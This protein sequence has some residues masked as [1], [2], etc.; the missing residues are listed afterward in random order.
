MLE[1][2]LGEVE[3][4]PPLAQ[5]VGGHPLLD[6]NLS[7]SWLCLAPMAHGNSQAPVA[8]EGAT[9]RNEFSLRMYPPR[10][11]LGTK[12]VSES[13][14]IATGPVLYGWTL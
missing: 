3:D 4:P 1:E 8:Q 14:S 7:R 5:H 10:T 13:G 2:P 9:A 11:G 12:E 6:T